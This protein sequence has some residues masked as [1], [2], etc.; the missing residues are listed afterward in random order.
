VVHRLSLIVITAV[1]LFLTSLSLA[2]D[3]G[4]KSKVL[5]TEVRF[6]R[7]LGLPARELREYTQYLTNRPL[8]RAK[9]LEGAS[10]AVESGLRHR[11]YLKAQVTAKLQRVRG[12][13]DPKGTQAILELSVRAGKQ[14]RVKEI[15]FAGA[16]NE[17]SEAELRRA[18]N[19]QPGDLADAEE[20]SAGIGNLMTE[21]RRKG[22]E[23]F[24]VP[25]MVLDDATSTV[26][27][28]FDI[29]R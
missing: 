27:L 24:V 9:V 28:R 26:S 23:V 7:E 15:S 4:F 10:S 21:F 12:P 13:I 8:E 29:R 20:I 18:F 1:L 3:V 6:T 22:K 5:V 16:A 19:I 11:G 25:N 2:Q 14:Y 17:L